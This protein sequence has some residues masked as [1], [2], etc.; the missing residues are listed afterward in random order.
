MK[1]VSCMVFIV[2]SLGLSCSAE[3]NNFFDQMMFDQVRGSSIKTVNNLRVFGCL[4]ANR[5]TVYDQSTLGGLTT[6]SNMHIRGNVV[7]DGNMID[8]QGIL[9]IGPGGVSPGATGPTGPTGATGATGAG[10]SA[11]GYAFT[12]TPAAAVL[13]NGNIVFTTNGPLVGVTNSAGGLT[14][15]NAGTYKISFIITNNAAITATQFA[16][17]SQNLSGAV[18][19]GIYGTASG[20]TSNQLFGQA[21]VTLTAGDVINIQNISGATF[22]FGDVTNL[23]VSASISIEQVG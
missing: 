2:G 17:V 11:Y 3:D 19:G 12:P 23:A 20:G 9:L 8:S 22:T 4:S 18:P 15:T 5:L 16:I 13:A 6:L 10:L 7:L 21:T 1:F 14:I